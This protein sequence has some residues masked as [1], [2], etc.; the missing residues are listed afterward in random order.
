MIAQAV[1]Y[2]VVTR[3]VWKKGRTNSPKTKSSLT[4]SVGEGKIML[5]TGCVVFKVSST[6]CATGRMD[7]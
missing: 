6:V 4:L 5:R 7:G 2:I 3:Y 1:H